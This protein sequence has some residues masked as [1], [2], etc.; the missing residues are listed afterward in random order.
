M[1]FR[2]IYWV[3][4]RVE[5]DGS[6]RVAGIYTSIPDL[7]DHGFRNRDPLRDGQSIRLSQVQLN[8]SDEPL[9]QWTQH[10]WGDIAQELEPFVESGEYS[11]EECLFLQD[12]LV[13]FSSKSSH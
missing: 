2:R 3:I 11:P 7:V 9:G 6:S 10:T 4:E 1:M 8:R 12:S 13:E 5:K